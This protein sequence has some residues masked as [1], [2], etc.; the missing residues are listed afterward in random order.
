MR[1]DYRVY[2]TRDGRLVKQGD[3]DA[4]FLEYPAGTEVADSVL[5]EHGLVKESKASAK[6]ADKA[7]RKPSDK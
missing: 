4:A 5:K 6:P 2:R 7:V 3:P 1:V